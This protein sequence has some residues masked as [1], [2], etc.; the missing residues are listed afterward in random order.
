MTLHLRALNIFHLWLQSRWRCR[1]SWNINRWR[2]SLPDCSFFGKWPILNLSLDSLGLISLL[3][4]RNCVWR[5]SFLLITTRWL[6]SNTI[7]T[8]SIFISMLSYRSSHRLLI[9]LHRAVVISKIN[10]LILCFWCFTLFCN[11][12]YFMLLSRCIL[13]NLIKILFEGAYHV[14]TFISRTTG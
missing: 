1:F 4:R 14:I 9:T 7:I 6:F 8:W 13:S 11:L 5:L 3:W 12:Y 10:R 2:R